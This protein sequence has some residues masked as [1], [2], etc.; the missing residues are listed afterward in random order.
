MPTAAALSPAG[1]PVP[2]EPTP[3][4]PVNRGTALPRPETSRIG[5]HHVPVGDTQHRPAMPPRYRRDRPGPGDTR[6]RGVRARRRGFLHVRHR[7]RRAARGVSGVRLGRRTGRHRLRGRAGRERHH[8]RR[9]GWVRAGRRRRTTSNRTAGFAQAEGPRGPMPWPSSKAQ[10][11]ASS[12]TPVLDVDR[13]AARTHRC[14][15]PVTSRRAA[16]WSAGTRAVLASGSS[17]LE[18]D[19][20]GHVRPGA[21]AWSPRPASHRCTPGGSPVVFLCP[22]VTQALGAFSQLNSRHTRRPAG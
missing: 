10:Q 11:E 18:G 21:P 13:R 1:R 7:R 15:P 8:P 6:T 14:S 3:T 2:T 20:A 16:S 19:I 17:G 5:R 22:M 12:R 4:R 9:R